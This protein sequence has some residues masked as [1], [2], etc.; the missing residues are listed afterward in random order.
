MPQ[1]F[2]STV[3]LRPPHPL[4][5][6]HRAAERPTRSSRPARAGPAPKLPPRTPGSVPTAPPPGPGS[7]R[8]A[9]VAP[10]GHHAPRSVRRRR[11][12]RATPDSREH[13]LPCA[14]PIGTPLAATATPSPSALA[15]SMRSS[16][17]SPARR[18]RVTRASPPKNRAQPGS[19][20]SPTRADTTVK[21]LSARSRRS[22][23]NTARDDGRSAHCR[24]SMAS[25]TT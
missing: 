1:H 15:S 25:T 18:I 4:R 20:S 14:R 5:S 17:L 6:V 8:R 3:R 23:N 16:G 19:V 24:S 10:A 9:P 2:R 22:A 21:T 13:F 12:R 11:S 7:P